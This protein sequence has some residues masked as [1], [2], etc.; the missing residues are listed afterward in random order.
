MWSFPKK[1]YQVREYLSSW[2]EEHGDEFN[3]VVTEIGTENEQTGEET[4]QI[5]KREH[6]DIL[7]HLE[8]KGHIAI[9]KKPSGSIRIK[10][11]PKKK[12]TIGF[13]TLKLISQELAEYYTGTEIVSFL[14]NEGVDKR[15]IIHPE[16]KWHIFY[17]VLTELATSKIK[18][19]EELLFKIITDAIHP[20][21]LGGNPNISRELREK[22]DYWLGYDDLEIWIESKDSKEGIYK[23]S[24]KLTDVEEA[25]AW[26]ESHQQ[27]IEEEKKYIEFLSKPKNKENISLL[28]KSFQALMSTV[29]VFCENPSSPTTELNNT[30]KF[31]KKSVW[32]TIEALGL[33]KQNFFNYNEYKF[34]TYSPPFVNLFVAEKQYQD[35]RKELS[36]HKIR[37]EMNAVFGGIDELYQ[38][39][40]GSDTLSEPDKQK[41]LNKITLYLSELKEKSILDDKKD[42]ESKQVAIDFSDTASRKA[43]EKKWDVLQAIWTTYNG[44]SQPDNLLVRASV[45]LIKDRSDTEINGIF[46]GLKKDGCFTDWQTTKD[47]VYFDIKDINHNKFIKIYQ[48]TGLIYNKFAKV[49]QDKAGD[50]IQKIQIVSGSKMEVEG[51][52]D[53][54]KSIAKAKKEDKNKFPYK[55]PAGTRW[56]NFIIKFVDAEN[57]DI[58][59]RQFKHTANYQDIVPLGKGKIPKPSVLWAFLKVLAQLGGEISIEDKEKRDEYKKQKELLTKCFQEYFSIDYDLFYPYHSA[60]GKESQTYRIKITLIPLPEQTPNDDGEGEDDLGI[61]EEYKKQTPLV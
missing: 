60:E 12:P 22:F 11:L 34:V 36:W 45:L 55:L 32:D 10:I 7:N 29:E 38:K 57:I 41:E 18:E 48:D 56:E 44:N 28:R 26:E 15:F 61:A 51:L 24:H 16:T 2:R 53:G 37:P 14:K 4:I 21:N 43:W 25:E 50:N 40:N 47:K 23:I 33:T 59:V 3:Y 20:L 27:D 42:N 17:F 58:Q 13:K 8:N 31:L 6:L 30:Y 52:Q 5:S 54:L 1:V 35:E 9:T 19:D 46:D 49:Y 39:V